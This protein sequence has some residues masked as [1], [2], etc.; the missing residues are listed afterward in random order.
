MKRALILALPLVL[1]VGACGDDDDDGADTTA[2][3]TETAVATETSAATEPSAATEATSSDDTTADDST[4][5]TDD[6]LLPGG[7]ILPGGSILPGGTLLP[8]GTIP[9]LSIPERVENELRDALAATGLTDEQI[10][11]LI[12]QFD[13]GSGQVPDISDMPEFF[14]QCD[15]NLAD[16]APGG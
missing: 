2:T 1:A 6:D 10:D 11:C 3:V 4:A 15:I 14:E 13:I 16:L 5:G 8:G 9:D 7:T 12:E